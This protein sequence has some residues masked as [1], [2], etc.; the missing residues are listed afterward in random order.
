[1]EEEEEEGRRKAN[2]MGDAWELDPLMGTKK[3][4]IMFPKG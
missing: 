3:S 1:M 4:F 2:K